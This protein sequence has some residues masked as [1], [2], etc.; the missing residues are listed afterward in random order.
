MGRRR[1]IAARATRLAEGFPASR[2]P[3][4]ESATGSVRL[5][6]AL[7]RNQM[8]A[9]AAH[10]GTNRYTGQTPPYSTGVEK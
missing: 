2:S 7:Y 8:F 10:L 3:G 6:A 4:V 1:A 5:E 9:T